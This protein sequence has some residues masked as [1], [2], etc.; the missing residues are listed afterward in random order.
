MSALS[1]ILPVL[2]VDQLTKFIILK[3]FQPGGSLPVIKNFF[4]ISLVCNK[5]VAFG[6]F[7]EQ[8][9]PFRW[10]FIVCIIIVVFIS[11]FYKK[12]FRERKSTRIFLSLIL[13]GAS[14]NLIDRIRFG[15][16]VDFLDFRIWPV[17]NIAD[18]AI[19]IGTVL[20][21]LQMLRHKKLLNSK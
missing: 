8:G 18:S 7:S 4:H 16:V 13:S 1:V 20:L 21:I 15:Y 3:N 6:V 11:V 5:G 2:I 17:F 10:T 14:G 9:L 12:L 19:T